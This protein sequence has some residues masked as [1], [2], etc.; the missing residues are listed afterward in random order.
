MTNSPPLPTGYWTRPINA[1]NKGWWEVADNWL[2]RDYD[3]PSRSFAGTPAFAPYTSAPDSAHILWTKPIVPGGIVGGTFGDTV[4]YHGI[5]Y[6]Q[7]FEAMVMQGIVFYSE[8][9]LT[10]TSAKLW[11]SILEPLHGRR[12]PINVHEQHKHPIRTDTKC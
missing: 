3:K 12:L 5:S 10:G 11:Y 1:E 9:G 4:W 8:H 2:M 6:E 7:F